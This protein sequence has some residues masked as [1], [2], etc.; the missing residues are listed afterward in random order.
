MQPYTD[1]VLEERCKE[2]GDKRIL[3][4]CPAFVS[5]CLETTIEISVEYQEEFEEFGGEHVQLVPSLNDH[6]E[7][8]KTVA[9]MVKENTLVEV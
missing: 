2:H 4:F 5:D 6:P 9:E 7:W 8:I 1:K 3:V